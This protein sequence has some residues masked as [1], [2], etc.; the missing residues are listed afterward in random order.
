M[1]KKN[2][3]KVHKIVRGHLIQFWICSAVI[4]TV[5]MAMTLQWNPF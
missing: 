2:K 5:L 1:K 4:L 3:K